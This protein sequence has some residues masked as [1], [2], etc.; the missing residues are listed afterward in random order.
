MTQ[1]CIITDST[2]LFPTPFFSGTELVRVL[3]MQIHLNGKVYQEGKGIKINQ[4]PNSIESDPQ[5][6]VSLPST[7]TLGQTLRNLENEHQEIIFL[8][9]SS[10][11]HPL[12]KQLYQE[13]EKLSSSATI[14]VLDSHTTAAGLGLLVQAA[15][16]ACQQG[17]PA[18]E[19]TRLLRGLIPRIY[20]IFCFQS[21]SYLRRAGHIDRAQALVGEVMGLSP[22]FILEN[23]Q[24]APIQ[25]VSST[26]NLVD[27]FHEFITEVGSLQHIALLKGAPVLENESRH[28]RDRIRID[29]P[30]VP[31]SEHTLGPALGTIFGP[32]TLGIVAMENE[33]R[34]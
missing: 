3:P 27:V 6:Q 33:P 28:L 1:A 2:A 8:F 10:L 25:K 4:L 20:M 7:E 21:L 18:L 14:H 31:Y 22:I 32:Q 34:L 29:F 9:L 15:A 24:L 5:P 12:M 11:L 26:R 30:K 13:A 23:G 16:K 17:L 19:V